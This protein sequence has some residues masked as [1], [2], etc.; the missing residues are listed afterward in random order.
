MWRLAFLFIL[1]SNATLAC[2]FCSTSAVVDERRAQCFS[3]IFDDR[4][5]RLQRS[6]R[7]FIQID[8]D[9][10]DAG[11]GD[12]SAARAVGTALDDPSGAYAEGGNLILS[13]Q[14]MVCLQAM[15]VDKSGALDPGLLIVVPNEC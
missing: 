14:Q 6:D 2:E 13:E 10:C 4:M 11:N 8:L 9:S 5:E 7:G 1:F 15:I 3:E 12:D